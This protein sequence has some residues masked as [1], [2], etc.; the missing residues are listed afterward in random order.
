VEVYRVRENVWLKKKALTLV[1]SVLLSFVF[2]Y[3]ACSS[4]FAQQVGT[5]LE[6]VNPGSGAVG[7]QVNVQGTI[8]TPNGSYLV[9]FWD[10]LVVNNTSKEYSVDS[11][12]TVP[13]LTAGNFNIT[14]QDATSNHSA[15]KSFTITTVAPFGISTIPWS[16]LSIM[17]VSFTI[18]LLN[19]VANRL[20]ITRFV[21]WEQ[22]RTMQKEMSEWRSQ[23]MAAVRANDK[24]Q[25]EK[26]KKKESQVM[27]MQK[28]MA[29]PQLILFALT[30][31]YFFIW[32]VLTGFY[33][34]P[35]AYV[36]GF[37]AVPFFIW[38]LMCS[39]F[40]GTISGRIIGIMPME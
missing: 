17:G 5:N 40:F 33:P 15:T 8:D 10:Q 16:T 32:P 23:Q 34:H 30:F 35:V 25:L 38:Y 31:V 18:A 29:K 14:L 20:L 11:N 13:N 4:V 28:K 2:L 24:K 36:P 1:V 27:S 39:L 7:S 19:S 26:L 37:G 6:T 9:Y 3:V 22:Y 21:G 12:F